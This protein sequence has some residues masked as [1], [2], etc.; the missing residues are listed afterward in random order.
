MLKK[1]PPRWPQRYFPSAA[2]GSGLQW[3]EVVRFMA[4]WWGVFLQQPQI[5]VP[6]TYWKSQTWPGTSRGFSFSGVNQNLSEQGE[7]ASHLLKNLEFKSGRS[8]YQLPGPGGASKPNNSCEDTW[9]FLG[10]EKKKRHTKL[11][12]FLAFHTRKRRDKCFLISTP[13]HPRDLRAASLAETSF[14]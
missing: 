4:D 8:N 6:W 1:F 5:M 2:L 3:Q 14:P 13:S 11:Q 10:W 12:K 9:S 7:V